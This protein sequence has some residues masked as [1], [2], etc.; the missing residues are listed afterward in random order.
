MKNRMFK[1]WLFG[2]K[3]LTKRQADLAKDEL[4]AEHW[5]NIDG[6]WRDTDS[7]TT[8]CRMFVSFA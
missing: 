1:I 3:L 8:E 7:P 6:A 5:D 2:V 4:E